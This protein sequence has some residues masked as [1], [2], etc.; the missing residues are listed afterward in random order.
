MSYFLGHSAKLKIRI[1]LYTVHE[2][3]HLLTIGAGLLGALIC[4]AILQ[5]SVA[6]S[7]SC[8][9]GSVRRLGALAIYY[10]NSP[11]FGVYGPPPSVSISLRLGCM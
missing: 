2:E 8:T 4:T 3:S 7:C 9:C 1:R 6:V 10:A 11:V 5:Q